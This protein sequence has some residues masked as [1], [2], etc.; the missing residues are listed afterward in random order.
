MPA[1]EPKNNIMETAITI[2]DLSILVD[3]LTQTNLLT[4]LQSDRPFSVFNPI[5]DA[6]QDLLDSNVDLN[7]L[8]D[9]PLASLEAVLN[10]HIGK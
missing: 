9:I 7:S 10:Y 6:L 5:N 4:A 2:D 3:A 1:P 8:D